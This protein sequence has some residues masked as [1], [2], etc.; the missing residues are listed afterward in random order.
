MTASVV[1]ITRDQ[2]TAADLVVRALLRRDVPVARFDLGDFPEHLTQNAYLVPGRKRWTGALRGPVRDVDLSAVRSIWYR[3]PSV[4]QP[5][6]DMTTTERQWA[7]AE[8]TAGLGGLLA[9]LPGVHWVNHPTRNAEADHKPRQLAVADAL[10]LPVPASL[11]TNDP[12]HAR[13]FC[14]A[15]REHGVIYKPLRGGP[16]TENGRPVALYATTVTAAD[17]TDNVARTSHLFQARVPCAYA[18]R[19]T[20]VGRRLFAVR[21]DAPPSASTV[22]WRAVHDQL[23]YTRIDVP[24]DITDR[25]NQLM[26][27][28]GL[29]YAASDWIV[30]PDGVWTFIGDLNP[31]GQNAWLEA[32]TGAPIASALADE[33]AKESHR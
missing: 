8:A 1:V 6:A 17:I 12:E 30:T 26:D 13:A 25:V 27:A 22:D 14:E 29:V 31:N 15:Y 11:I 23:T 3:K 10:G 2:D 18:V 21:I 4:V 5:H 19:L 7:A 16:A 9:S 33:L 24:D 28:F 32:Q 20:I